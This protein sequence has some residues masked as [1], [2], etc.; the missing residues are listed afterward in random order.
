MLNGTAYTHIPERE[1][2]VTLPYNVK[3]C[4]TTG[5]QK[6]AL[7]TEVMGLSSWL[8]SMQDVAAALGTPGRYL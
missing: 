8:L 5:V 2:F 6:A 4:T 3:V 7:V 1:V